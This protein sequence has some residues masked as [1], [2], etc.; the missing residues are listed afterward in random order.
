[1]EGQRS[2]FYETFPK[3]DRDL[4]KLDG[5][6][7]YLSELELFR[8]GK[9]EGFNAKIKRICESLKAVERQVNLSFADGD[10]SRNEKE[11]YDRRI[12]SEREKCLVSNKENSPYWALYD[13]FLGLYQKE[14]NASIRERE[15]CYINDDCREGRQ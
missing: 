15:R 11:N 1:M 7:Q 12:A 5:L 14:A 10:L 8:I 6:L 13:D 3:V 2:L 9:L 4:P